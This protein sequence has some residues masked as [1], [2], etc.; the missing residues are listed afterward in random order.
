LPGFKTCGFQVK[1]K[2]KLNKPPKTKLRTN[3]PIRQTV[4]KSR[5]KKRKSPLFGKTERKKERKKELRP[6][7]KIEWKTVRREEI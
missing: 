6:V 1:K 2:K 3:Q 5:R 4:S 7:R